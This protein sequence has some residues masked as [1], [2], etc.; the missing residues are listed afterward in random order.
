MYLLSV[1]IHTS[2]YCV[3]QKNLK[4]GL[5]ANV[6]AFVFNKNDYNNFLKTPYS[7]GFYI[8]YSLT[9]E[10]TLKTR[11]YINNQKLVVPQ[12]FSQ[13]IRKISIPLILGRTMYKTD[14]QN[15]QIGVEGGF[16]W[17]FITKLNLDLKD[18][19]GLNFA[20]VTSLRSVS[21]IT[22]PNIIARFGFSFLK[23]LK[24]KAELQLYFHYNRTIQNWDYLLLETKN[25]I[26]RDGNYSTYEKSRYII[27]LSVNT[28]QVGIYYN[29]C[30]RCKN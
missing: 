24:N 6:G 10:Y 28:F 7:F 9:N 29:Y 22:R 16:S 4:L 13:D 11:L 26:I 25:D 14:D 27:D 3:A 19:F 8:D 5:G 12:F 15:L 21:N 23:Q 1:F 18:V 2:T 17:D 30:L 20:K